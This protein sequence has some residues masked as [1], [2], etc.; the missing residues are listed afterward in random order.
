MNA[1]PV[2]LVR[3]EEYHIAHVLKPLAAVFGRVVLGDTGSTDHTVEIARTI[4]T[5][6]IIELGPLPPPKLGQARAMLGRRVAE[7]GAPWMFQ[8]DGDELYT[9]ETLR[10]IAAQEIPVGKWAGFTSMC[11][12]D[13]DAETGR[14]WELRDVFSRLAILPAQVRWTGEYPFEIPEVFENPAN[15][16][17]VEP[18][19]GWPFHALHLHRLPRSDADGLVFLRKQKQYQFAMQDKDV[20]RTQ[21]LDEARWGLAGPMPWRGETSQAV[22]SSLW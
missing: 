3:N 2:V 8:V 4:P 17:Y 16:W 15:F 6:E 12:V 21:P 1:I 11:S 7:L 18:A 14:L 20:P 13:L 22:P 5:V 9:I 10:W 19:P